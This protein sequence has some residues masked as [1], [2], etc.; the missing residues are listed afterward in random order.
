MKA[1]NNVVLQIVRT[2]WF[3]GWQKSLI[4][5]HTNIS[6]TE[7]NKAAKLL[8]S[9]R[10]FTKVETDGYWERSLAFYLQDY[11]EPKLEGDP[12]M[13]RGG[14]Q[15]AL[16]NMLN[17]D[18]L[19]VIAQNISFTLD[20]LNTPDLTQLPDNYKFLVRNLFQCRAEV[21]PWMSV[22]PG[23][24][25]YGIVHEFLQHLIENKKRYTRSDNMAQGLVEWMHDRDA[26]SIY[27]RD[28][29][30][31]EG[32]KSLLHTLLERAI[33]ELEDETQREVIKLYYGVLGE[34]R[35][36]SHYDIAEKL[37]IK[38]A[39]RVRTIEGHALKIMRNR[40]TVLAE[41]WYKHMRVQMEELSKQSA[42]VIVDKRG[43]I[44]DS[45]PNRPLPR[46]LTREEF[47]QVNLDDLDFTVRTFNCLRN[48][49]IRTGKDL[50]SK[51]ERDLI[52]TKN[53]GRKSLAE[54]MSILQENN[55]A[56]QPD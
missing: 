43:I 29:P 8:R 52:A 16:W 18:G 54:I 30:F 5:R 20:S 3:L 19:A 11:H 22:A 24:E 12:G 28:V 37:G 34:D 39:H 33:L 47:E 13:I 4:L 35:I 50:L 42:Y 53:F 6:E 21:M 14:V 27:V 32:T 48:A 31:F 15:E 7:Y 40:N 26:R 17:L 44:S 41:Y 9:E 10:N 23:S 45:H 25:G 36:F 46:F 51:S 1:I 49:D 38:P 2:L 56:L 55:L